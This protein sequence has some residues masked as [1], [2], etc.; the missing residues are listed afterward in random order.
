[1]PL[2]YLR[3]HLSAAI[4]R[5]LVAPRVDRPATIPAE[6]LETALAGLPEPSRTVYLLHARDQLPLSA[7]GRRLDLTP[8]EVE[9]HLASALVHLDRQIGTISP[10]DAVA[11]GIADR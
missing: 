11:S 8:A 6:A 5:L 4:T 1:M 9:E 2:R 10:A 7:I 3:Q